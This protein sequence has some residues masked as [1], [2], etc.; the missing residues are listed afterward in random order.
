MIHQFS[1]IPHIFFFCAMTL[2]LFCLIPSAVAGEILLYVRCNGFLSFECWG[3]KLGS[4]AAFFE[5]KNTKPDD[6]HLIF[7]TICIQ[8]AVF[9]LVDF[10]K[11]HH[12]ITY[13][14][15]NHHSTK[16]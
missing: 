13:C 7:Y 3:I 14:I 9:Q 12:Q 1:L 10:L 15:I 4:L 8:L 11:I 6:Y 16:A 5:L 2:A